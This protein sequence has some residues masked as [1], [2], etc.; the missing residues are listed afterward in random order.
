[1]LNYSSASQALLLLVLTA[2][3]TADKTASSG[4]RPSTRFVPPLQDGQVTAP[5]QGARVAPSLPGGRDS[6]G[7]GAAPAA[8]SDS[9]P[10][11]PPAAD[12]C[13]PFGAVP[14]LVGRMAAGEAPSTCSFPD[15]S[16]GVSAGRVPSP[17]AATGPPL[18]PRAPLPPLPVPAG[19][20]RQLATAVRRLDAQVRLERRLS[21][22]APPPLPASSRLQSLHFQSDAATQHQGR[23][24]LRDLMVAQLANNGS[25]VAA[26]ATR[27]G[28]SSRRVTRRNEERVP[29]C[30]IEPET[31]CD[32]TSKY[33]TP[34]GSCNNL[35]VSYIP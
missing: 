20:E 29:G 34:D 2:C 19:A 22:E 3:T 17:P 31:S 7:G 5:L 33:R 8:A 16:I 30:E 21:G 6:G 23:R 24:A 10:R 18:R 13:M 9:G 11:A 15:G 26:E 27:S 32:R 35:R 14:G 4:R 1:M 25:S 28:T 12:D